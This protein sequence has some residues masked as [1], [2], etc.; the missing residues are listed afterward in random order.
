MKGLIYG[1]YVPDQQIQSLRQYER[2]YSA[3]NKRIVHAEQCMDMQLQRCNIRF[4]NYIS[5][6][7][8]QAM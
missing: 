7:C 3:L 8:S 2:R 4:S 5:D 1:S 6:I